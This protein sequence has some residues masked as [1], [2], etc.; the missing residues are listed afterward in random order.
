MKAHTQL[1]ER[2][3]FVPVSSSR[4]AYHADEFH[5]PGSVNASRKAL[6]G[7]VYAQV[8]PLV[9][10]GSEL[11][12]GSQQH[13]LKSDF[14]SMYSTS[15]TRNPS[16]NVSHETDMRHQPA[17]FTTKM[18]INTPTSN[19]HTLSSPPK[20]H[21]KHLSTS[22]TPLKTMT[23]SLN[24]SYAPS[25]PPLSIAL[26]IPSLSM[27][28]TAMTDTSLDGS[29]WLHGRKDSPPP[30]SV[31]QTLPP[32][33]AKHLTTSFAM[34]TTAPT[35][36]G[37][38]SFSNNE[39]TYTCTTPAV[40]GT[41]SLGP[42]SQAVRFVPINTAV[43][44]PVAGSNVA[45]QAVSSSGVITANDSTAVSSSS[46]STLPMFDV[47]A[48]LNSLGKLSTKP[49]QPSTHTPNSHQ[50]S[51]PPTNSSTSADRTPFSVN[52]EKNTDLKDN[53]LPASNY[54]SLPNLP[55]NQ[56][57]LGR[58]PPS[59]AHH[60]LSPLPVESV[61]I[62]SSSSHT[63]PENSLASVSSSQSFGIDAQRE[64]M[65]FR[66][67]E[68]STTPGPIAQ[69]S[70]SEYS[71]VSVPGV[72]SMEPTDTPPGHGGGGGSVGG[73]RSVGSLPAFSGSSRKTGWFALS[74]HLSSQ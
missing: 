14:H 51:R 34:G 29:P 43:S 55:P 15:T 36:A 23:S 73:S 1:T 27:N 6:S 5:S 16:A 37:H 42:S 17:S 57:A 58:L 53:R 25:P 54:D 18:G 62:S 38:Q 47:A 11:V 66:P 52:K 46:I 19:V 24:S 13:T 49:S 68:S 3:V 41:N 40:T 59:K 60:S 30:K 28:T 26:Q 32:R 33:D 56:S 48:F 31:T 74:T 61:I 20:F 39:M 72:G 67:L 71:T 50:L 12:K 35:I 65:F 63:P 44:S 22:F 69:S 70:S 2:N 9:Q 7:V 10:G 45:S 8:S 21:S 64:E 4:V